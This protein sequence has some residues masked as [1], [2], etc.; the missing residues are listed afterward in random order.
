MMWDVSADCSSEDEATAPAHKRL[1]ADVIEGPQSVPYAAVGIGISSVGWQRQLTTNDLTSTAWWAK[2]MM[3]AL[4][5]FM[6]KQARPVVLGTACSG[7]E[8]PAWA[9]QAFCLGVN[10]LI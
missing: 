7:V 8:A 3:R 1:R 10:V 2:P 5:P 6:P 9:L 4:S